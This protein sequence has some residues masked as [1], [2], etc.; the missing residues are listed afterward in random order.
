L[1]QAQVATLATLGPDGRPQATLLWFLAGEDGSVSMS[2]N[3]SRQKVKNL[4][5][6]PACALVIVDPGNPYRYLEIRGDA[7]VAPDA[8][9][10]F[11]KKVGEKYGADLASFDRPGESRVK[12]T[13]RPVKVNAVTMR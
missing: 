1:L 8:D 4:Q 2:L 13:L 3:T 12:V 7:Q 9:Y 10:S 11:A 6:N 5:R